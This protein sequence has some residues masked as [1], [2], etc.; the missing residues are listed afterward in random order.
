MKTM[1]I[2]IVLSFLAPIY[3]YKCVPYEGPTH[4][5]LEIN[6]YLQDQA[7]DRLMLFLDG[8]TNFVNEDDLIYGSKDLVDKVYEKLD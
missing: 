1:W 3:F 5:E 6:Y 8:Y 2:F 7:D 4:E